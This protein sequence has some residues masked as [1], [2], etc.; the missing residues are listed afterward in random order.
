MKCLAKRSEI[1]RVIGEIRIT[2]LIFTDLK[3]HISIFQYSRERVLAR[4]QINKWIESTHVV[5]NKIRINF[6][7]LKLFFLLFISTE[8]PTFH[9]THASH[10]MP[11][12][13]LTSMQGNEFALHNRKE[14]G[15]LRISQPLAN[16][17]W[18]CQF[19]CRERKLKSLKFLYENFFLIFVNFLSWGDLES[20]K[21]FHLISIYQDFVSSLSWSY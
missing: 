14:N 16:C 1:I 15:S 10:T 20:L 13:L 5:E 9:R 11:S 3:S 17:C 19:N 2:K 6:Y 4:V 21:F 12:M 7:L 8:T 18:T